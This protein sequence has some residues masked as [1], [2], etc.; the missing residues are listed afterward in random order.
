MW[1]AGDSARMQVHMETSQE[2]LKEE[3]GGML[4]DLEARFRVQMEELE[5]EELV[6]G[7]LVLRKPGAGVP[8]P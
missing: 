5:M 2:G 7:S 8:A 6:A 4:K 1:L 3:V